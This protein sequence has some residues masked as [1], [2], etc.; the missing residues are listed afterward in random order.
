MKYEIYSS[1]TV[2][3]CPLCKKTSELFYIK[4]LKAYF[5]PITK[6]ESFTENGC[7]VYEAA[8]YDCQEKLI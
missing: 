6:E 1:E 8:C 4:E 3:K 2:G 7:S 5:N